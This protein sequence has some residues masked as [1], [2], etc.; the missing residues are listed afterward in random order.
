MRVVGTQADLDRAGLAGCV[1]VPTMGAMHAGHEALIALAAQRAGAPSGVCVSVFVNPTQFNEASDFEKYP[2][3]LDADLRRCESL[4]VGTVFAPGPE[5]VYPPG[6]EIPVEPLPAVAT[7][8]GLEDAFRPGHFAGVCQVV[9]RLFDLVRPAAAVF[10]EKDWQQLQVVRAM[11]AGEGLG[12]EIIPGPTVREPD[13]LAMSSRNTR[14]D[15]TWRQR[16]SGIPRAFE[17][18]SEAPTPAEAERAM[19]RVLED[20]GLAV[21]YAAVREASALGPPEADR[22]CRALIACRAGG[23]RLIDNRSWAASQ[24]G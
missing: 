10:G 5:T 9:R 1:L 2:R 11:V 23:V 7:E 14:L 20:S 4:G 21:E 12:V 16:A 6:R 19:R 3:D 15:A 24:G 22:P 8:P 13:G 17:A 18:A